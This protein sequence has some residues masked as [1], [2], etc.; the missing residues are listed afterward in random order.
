MLFRPIVVFA[1]VLPIFGTMLGAGIG[2][3][4]FLGAAIL[5]FLVIAAAWVFYRPLIG[6]TMIVLA[7]A[8]LYWLVSVG[9]KKKAV[10]A[11]MVTAPVSV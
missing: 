7:I 1:D 4:A 9:R 8:A 5:S 2:L 6:I 10:R 3:F 11:G